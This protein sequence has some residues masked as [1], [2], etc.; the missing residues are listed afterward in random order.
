MLSTAT[1]SIAEHLESTLDRMRQPGSQICRNH[2]K[3]RFNGDNWRWFRVH[4]D[5]GLRDHAMRKTLQSWLDGSVIVTNVAWRRGIPQLFRSA[6]TN[7]LLSVLP[8]SES[9]RFLNLP[10][11]IGW[12]REPA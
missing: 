8:Q 3:Q 12:A 7:G 1:R 6:E 11:Q 9:C 5:V 2:C 10:N 4:F